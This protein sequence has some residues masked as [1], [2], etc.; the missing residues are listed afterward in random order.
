M[1]NVR[2]VDGRVALVF[3]DS[4]HVRFVADILD[5]YAK[6]HNDSGALQDAHD[7]SVAADDWD[8]DGS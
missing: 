6:E 1:S 2:T 7:L 4:D 8:A 5:T 3:E